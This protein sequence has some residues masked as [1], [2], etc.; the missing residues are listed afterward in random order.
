MNEKVQQTEESGN[1]TETKPEKQGRIKALIKALNN[2]AAKVSPVINIFNLSVTI[3]VTVVVMDIDNEM[4][5]LQEELKA[6]KQQAGKAVMATQEA[7]KMAKSLA[8]ALQNAQLSINALA[9]NA[10]Q[11]H[12]EVLQEERET[13]ISLNQNGLVFHSPNEPNSITDCQWQGNTDLTCR[14][15]LHCSENEGIC[16]DISGVERQ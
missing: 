15:T 9:A 11:A 1:L 6:A 3:G 7:A 16:Y 5:A 13:V 8:D 14:I 12:Q 2:F 4:G 10:K